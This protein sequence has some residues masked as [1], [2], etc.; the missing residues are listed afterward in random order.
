MHPHTA[1][2]GIAAERCPDVLVIGSGMGGAA[3]AHALL[4]AGLRV[5]MVERGPRVR[6][7]AH[8]AA[9]DAV[10]ELSPYYTRESAYLVR[11]DDPGVAG[12]FHCVGGPS[13]FYGGV[14]L[15]L[16][17]SDFESPPDIV[18]DTGARWPYGYADLEPYYAWA[19]ELLEVAG[20]ERSFD[21]DPSRSAPYPRPALEPLGPSRRILE[22]AASLGLT[23]SL[24][25]LAIRHVPGGAPGSAC[26]RCG[27]CDGYACSVSA[28][29]EPSTAILPRLEQRGLLLLPDTVV[30]R[31]LRRGSQILGAECVHRGTGRRWIA[32]ADHYVLA[33]GTLASPR[34]V[35]AAG[36]HAASPAAAWIGRGLMRHCNAIVYGVFREPL[37]GGRAFHKQ[38]GIFDFYG[39]SWAPPVGCL[40][41]IHPPPPGLVRSRVPAWLE[42]LA[43]PLADHA[44]GL[45]AIAEDQP[46]RE[47][48]LELHARRTDRFGVPIGVVTHRYTT[49]DRA[50]RDVLTFYG[51]RILHRAGAALTFRVRIRTFSHAVGTLRMGLDPRTSPLDASCR[52]RGLDN[53]SV[54]DGS[55]LPRSAAVNPSLTIAA[56][57]LKAAC[58]LAGARPR[59]AP[60]REPAY[61]PP[62]LASGSPR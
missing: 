55:C 32:R 24:L 61:G 14:A 56:N 22:A 23:P 34:I 60:A 28:K 42:P 10:M 52:F 57:A 33:A 38:I 43:E 45:L 26:T 62:V 3:A 44:T 9:P 49:R 36:L 8:N 50:A 46:R 54:F 18:G 17:E 37:E 31:L 4:E 47:N 51:S 20:P 59:R 29:R 39:G 2:D 13:V 35:L 19:E 53:L 58:E 6:R 21:G 48:R 11:G 40:Q 1:S 27:T 41:S 16:R 7:G 15:R 12:S 30:T 25:P 5:W